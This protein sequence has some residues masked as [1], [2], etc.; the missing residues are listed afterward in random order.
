MHISR[1]NDAA[2]VLA[3]IFAQAGIRFG[4]FGGYAIAVRGG[5]RESKDVDCLA[6]GVTKAQLIALLDGKDGFSVIPTSREDYVSFFWSNNPSSKDAVLVE[7]FPDK[8]TGK[9]EWSLVLGCQL[10]KH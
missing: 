7:I 5:P 2:I 8:F 10:S 3:R 4:I 9:F 1:L 6:S